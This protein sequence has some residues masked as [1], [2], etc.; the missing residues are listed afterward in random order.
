MLIV[1]S[2]KGTFCTKHPSQQIVGK[3]Q[4]IKEENI[5]LFWSVVMYFWTRVNA[6]NFLLASLEIFNKCVA[7]LSLLSNVTPNTFSCFVFLRI[8]SPHTRFV[9]NES[10]N[11]VKKHDVIVNWWLR[12]SIIVETGL[13][14]VYRV[15][16]S[17][18]FARSFFWRNK[19]SLMKIFKG[20]EPNTDPRASPADIFA[21]SL[22]YKCYL[23]C[24]VE[25]CLVGSF[26]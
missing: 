14:E 10:F 2:T 7:K 26:S 13:S 22:H 25:A 11:W 8:P 12:E 21:H 17:A 3:L 4:L 23:F 18:Q 16:S 19:M 9:C 20:S 6:L 24:S 1:Y 15:L 5:S